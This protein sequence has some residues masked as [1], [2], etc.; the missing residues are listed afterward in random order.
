MEFDLDDDRLLLVGPPHKRPSN[1][2]TLIA[3]VACTYADMEVTER[4][5]LLHHPG[6]PESWVIEWTVATGSCSIDNIRVFV[7]GRAVFNH[8][9]MYI[10]LHAGDSF[11]LSLNINGLRGLFDLQPP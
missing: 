9:Q 11:K 3:Y 4:L 1:E 6:E 2:P 5:P 10:Y 8:P 7:H